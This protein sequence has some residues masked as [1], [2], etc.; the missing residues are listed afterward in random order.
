MPLTPKTNVSHVK[1]KSTKKS[2]TIKKFFFKV[3]N[4]Y[5]CAKLIKKKIMRKFAFFTLLFSAIVVLSGCLTSQY[6][7]YNI[8]FDTKTSGTLTI[9]YINIYADV[10]EDENADSVVTSDYEDLTENYVFGDEIE[11]DFPEA[12]VVEKVLYEEN[13][14]LCA[15]LVL[16]FTDPSQVNLYKHD[17]KSPWM[18]SIPSDEKYFDATT[19]EYVDLLSMMFWD[20]NFKG[21]FE[22]TTLIQE[23]EAEDV[24]L[25]QA[26]KDN[27]VQWT[28]SNN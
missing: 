26:F 18:F 27:P 4:S 20:R 8:H 9:K 1:L 15:R 13:G 3:L 19:G 22:F 5:I 21:D 14:Q 24:S 28:N 7:E 6:K 23:P 16:S 12:T 25:L 10:F 2:I 11:G 17:K